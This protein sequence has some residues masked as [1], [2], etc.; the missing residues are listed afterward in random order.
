MQQF[1]VHDNIARSGEYYQ[2]V[3]MRSYIIVFSTRTMKKMLIPVVAAG[4]L[5]ALSSVSATALA[6]G[7]CDD[8]LGDMQCAGGEGSKGGGGGGLFKCTDT[9]CFSGYHSGGSGEGITEIRMERFLLVEKGGDIGAT[10][11]LRIVVDLSGEVL[12]YHQSREAAG[13]NRNSANTPLSF[14]ELIYTFYG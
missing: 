8:L 2:L 4:L 10:M 7:G 13:I 11:M 12:V 14:F 5:L 3:H 6:R 1:R 9:D